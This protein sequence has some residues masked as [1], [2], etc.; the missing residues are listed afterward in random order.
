MTILKVRAGDFREGRWPNGA[1]VSWTIATEPS[2]AMLTNCCWHFA[3]ALIERSV[4]FSF[5]PGIDRVLTLLEG[6]GFALCLADGR[7]IAVN[8]CNTPVRFPGDVL[9][10]CLVSSAPSRVLNVLF[11]RSLYRPDVYVGSLPLAVAEDTEVA[12][13]YGLTDAFTTTTDESVI[14]FDQGEAAVMSHENSRA[15]CVAP[16]RN[17]NLFVAQLVPLRISA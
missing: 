11:A 8:R 10:E 7:E 14:E 6:P 5:L 17:G 9:T 15:T 13:A 2:A 12:L 16:E 1:G 4:P 3:T